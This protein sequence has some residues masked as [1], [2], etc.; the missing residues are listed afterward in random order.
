M[1]ELLGCAHQ[2]KIVQPLSSSHSLCE[3]ASDAFQQSVPMDVEVVPGD[4]LRSHHIDSWRGLQ[5]SNPELN[6]PLFAPEFV[7][8]VAAVRSDIEVAVICDKGATVAFFP[9]QRKGQ[10]RAVPVGGIVSDY[11]GLICRPGFRCEPETLLHACELVAWDFDRLVPSQRGLASYCKLSEPSAQ[12]D[13]SEGFEAYA[14]DRQ[15]AGTYQLRYCEY[16]ARRLER[17]LGPLQFVHHYDEPAALAR[18]LAWKS[19]QYRNSG[20]DDLFANDWARG[21][22]QRIHGVQTPRFAGMLSVLYA[23][24]FLIAGHMGMRSDT[25]WHYW[26][27][28][29]ERRFAKYSPGMI[30]L[31]KMAQVAPEL[32]LRC[33]DLGTGLSLYKRRLM[34][35]SLEVVEGSA[36]TRSCLNLVRVGRRFLRGLGHSGAR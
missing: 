14:R 17:E 31:W 1:G 12:I 10:Y 32:G 4:R 21:L 19:E 33:I 7:Q 16:M 36:E 34:N 2:S 23:G 25:I 9:F 6:N 28:A 27:P 26:F 8:A 18:V 24:P 3:E 29:Y 30:L 35:A 15:R 5:E 22:A 11:H 20:W 13:L